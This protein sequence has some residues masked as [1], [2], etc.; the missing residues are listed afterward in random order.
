MG[1]RIH[2]QFHSYHYQRISPSPN[3]MRD[4]YF[5][6]NIC[7]YFSGGT[8]KIFASQCV[9]TLIYEHNI[10]VFLCLSSQKLARTPC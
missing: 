7:S 2:V 3:W 4:D 9:N 5:N 1:N 8:R 10:N 6:R